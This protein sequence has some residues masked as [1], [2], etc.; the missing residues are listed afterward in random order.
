ME[1]SKF[2]V[3]GKQDVRDFHAKCVK[4]FALLRVEVRKPRKSTKNRVGTG[5]AL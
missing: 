3:S 5:Y 4:I 1:N 2:E